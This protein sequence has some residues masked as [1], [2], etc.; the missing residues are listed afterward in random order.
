[1]DQRSYSQAVTQVTEQGFDETRLEIAKQVAK[2]N[3]LTSAQV[4]DMM[5]AFGFEETRLDFA[6]FAYPYCYDPN[7]YFLVNSAFEFESSTEE[8]ARFTRP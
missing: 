1:M 8:L 2:S 4:R 7:N 5:R 6:K 3:C